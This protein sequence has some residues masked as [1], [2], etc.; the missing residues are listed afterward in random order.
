MGDIEFKSSPEFSLG[1][2]IELQLLN[3]DTLQLVDGILPLLAQH[4]ENSWIQPEC[5]QAMV[6]IA[7]QVCS[8]IPEL[9][10]NIFAILRDLKAR[11]Q[12]SM[13]R[14][15]CLYHPDSQISESA[16]YIWLSGRFNDDLC[17]SDSCRNAIG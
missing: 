1:M 11:C 16:K 14:S 6:E 5:N 13:L 2:E 3:P 10:A 7:S 17:A 8:N 12:Q 15:L 4:P 9:E